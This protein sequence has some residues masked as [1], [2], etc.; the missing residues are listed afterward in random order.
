MVGEIGVKHAPFR[1]FYCLILTLLVFLT[2]S[3]LEFV[4]MLDKALPNQAIQ[5]LNQVLGEGT[6]RL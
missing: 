5:Y 2:L 6:A 4:T 3:M 1:G